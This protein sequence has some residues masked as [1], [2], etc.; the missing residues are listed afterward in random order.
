MNKSS[1]IR[2]HGNGPR[3][4]QRHDL[5]HR[6]LVTLSLFPLRRS[7]APS[8]RRFPSL[9]LTEQPP[10]ILKRMTPH[11]QRHSPSAFLDIP[12]P[13]RMRPIVL[14]GLLHQIGLANRSLIH[15]PLQSQ[16]FWAKAQ[17]LGIHELHAGLLAGGDHAI[18]LLEISRQGFFADDVLAR[19]GGRFGV[20]T[21]QVI[22]APQHDHIH[23]FNR[24]KLPKVPKRFGYPVLFGEFVGVVGR[25]RCDGDHLSPGHALE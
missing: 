13:I 20:F 15:Q 23:L 10:K 12:K 17:L 9:R 3:F 25:R 16:I 6:R 11:V 19:F 21:M 7:V 2:Q 8:L 5:A 1:H 4:F 18:G 14:L 22:R 24:D